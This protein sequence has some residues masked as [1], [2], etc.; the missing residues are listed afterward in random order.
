MADGVSG[1][2]DY[3]VSPL[4]RIPSFLK[5]EEVTIL[6]KLA[7]IQGTVRLYTDI[8]ELTSFLASLVFP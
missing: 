1:A 5:L 4:N 7:F 2:L 8:L 3:P 6:P